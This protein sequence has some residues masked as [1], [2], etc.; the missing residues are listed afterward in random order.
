MPGATPP[1]LSR[2]F[3]ASD[4]SSRERAWTEF[5]QA[6]S[7]LLL[8]VARSFGGDYDSAMDRYAFVL[9]Q[10]RRDDFKRLR[11]YIAD[12]RSKFSTWLV[13][14]ARRLCLDY[15]RQRYGRARGSQGEEPTGEERAERKRLV[16][17]LVERV[18]LAVITDRSA[19]NPESE[20]REAELADALASA[21]AELQP[22]DRLILKLRFE[23]EVPVREIAEVIGLPSVFH[24]YRRLREIYATLRATLLRKGV[25]DPSP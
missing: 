22:R 7:R 10:L 21:L 11:A 18:D 20:L 5:V 13:V 17:F 25:E 15:H 9:K 4:P 2:L 19:R 16:D 12:A 6:H 24:V 23:D 8:H 3:S 1:E 14:V